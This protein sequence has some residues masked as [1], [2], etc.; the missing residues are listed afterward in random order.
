MKAEP[1]WVP[2]IALPQSAAGESRTGRV[3]ALL[4]LGAVA[5]LL[6]WYGETVQILVSTWRSNQTFAH[7][8]LIAPI[9]AW[10]I[11]R[12]RDEL[13]ALDVRPNYA[14]LPVLALA[15][16][17]WLLGSLTG[18]AIVQEYGLVLMIP[19]LAWTILGTR[20]VRVL[21]FPLAFL[22][23]AVPFGEVLLPPLMKYTADFTVFALRVTGIPV[24]R[25][26]LLFTIPSG[27]WSVVEACSGLRYLIACVTGGLLYAHLRYRS[28]A[29]RVIFVAI[30]V[31]VPVIANWLRAYLIVM[32]DHLSGRKLAMDVDHLLYGWVFFGIV[33]LALFWAG[34]Y[35]R[36][37]EGLPPVAGAAGARKPAASIPAIVAAALVAAVVV[38]VWPLAAQRIDL[39]PQLAVPRL[40][41]PMR[42][43][44]WKPVPGRLSSW[45]PNF[46]APSAQVNQLYATEQ[47]SAGL[48]LGYYGDQR[49]GAE[50]ITSRNTLVPSEGGVWRSAGE[51]HRTF[52]AGGDEHSAIEALLT[53]PASSLVV[54]RW[55]WVDGM[56]T[57]NPYW[58]KLL[59]ARA[60][61]LGRADD[62]A[63]V[64]IYTA[65]DEGRE[66][67]SARLGAFATA[68]LPAITKSLDYAR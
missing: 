55:Y 47:G 37:D 8:F 39:S 27:S 66:E 45:T 24:Y 35:W 10:L 31:V 30:A 56:Y 33:T 9:S 28:T 2:A 14:V 62:G 21:A 25:E 61:L 1:E 22:L 53:G 60:A 36:E 13:A 50:L 51:A 59:Q 52:V 43:G 4:A 19:L 58:A 42:S 48:Y 20:I 63:V 15:G 32:L 38:T 29:R 57:A 44:E 67:A 16:L 3:A 7:G 26:G 18:V 34:S 65:A 23:L 41:T 46:T 64:I 49:G 5:W 54:W 6:A 12:R 17:A 40:H 11:W 68:M